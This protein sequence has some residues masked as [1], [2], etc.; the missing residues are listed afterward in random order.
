MFYTTTINYPGPGKYEPQ[1]PKSTSCIYMGG[2][3][4]TEENTSSSPGP[5]YQTSASLLDR[6]KILSQHQRKGTVKIMMHTSKSRPIR[7]ELPQL[8]KKDDFGRKEAVLTYKGTKRFGQSGTT[9]IIERQKRFA[10]ETKLHTPGP[11]H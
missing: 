9:S 10:N 1:K 7:T 8:P 5:I 6:D 11:G 3:L 4:K 2:R